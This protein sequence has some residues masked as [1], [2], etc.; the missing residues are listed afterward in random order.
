MDLAVDQQRDALF[1]A[2]RGGAGLGQLIFEAG[3]QA[4]QFQ[5]AQLRQ[6][7]VHHHRRFLIGSSRGRAGEHGLG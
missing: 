3:R 4:V 2:E 7:G 6:G 5:G 1:E